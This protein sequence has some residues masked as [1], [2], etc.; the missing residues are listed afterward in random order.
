MYICQRCLLNS[1]CA[2]LPPPGPQAHSISFQLLKTRP[3]PA[4]QQEQL[5]LPQM[6]PRSSLPH[7]TQPALQ[8]PL[9]NEASASKRLSTAYHLST[10]VHRCLATDF[11]PASG[12]FSTLGAWGAAGAFATCS[13]V[14]EHF[15]R[16]Q[17]SHLTLGSVV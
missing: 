3:P 9:S 4:G 13:D 11:L 15:F 17:N 8:S 10:R 16:L 12:G 1:S 6:I 5:W 7:R 14:S 2:L